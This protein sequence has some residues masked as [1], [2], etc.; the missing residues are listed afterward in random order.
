MRA[1]VGV[2]V[3]WHVS[4]PELIEAVGRVVEG[5]AGLRFL[6]SPRYRART[7]ARWKSEKWPTIFFECVSAAI[8]VVLVALL[9][10]AVGFYLFGIGQT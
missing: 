2:N 10:Y 7:L 4:A 3:N 8:G 5:G 1:P 9:A 6:L